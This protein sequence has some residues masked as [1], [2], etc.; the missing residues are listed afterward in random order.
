[1]SQRFKF[2]QH[3]FQ[4]NTI[5]I[6]TIAHIEEAICYGTELVFKKKNL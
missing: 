1:M 5:I 2:Y 6:T 3:M 4:M